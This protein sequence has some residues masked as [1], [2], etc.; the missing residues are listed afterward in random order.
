MK[1]EGLYRN[2]YNRSSRKTVI[3]LIWC[4]FISIFLFF[5]VCNL[6]NDQPLTTNDN[7]T[8]VIEETVEE[9]TTS[10][11]GSEA[12][13]SST[14]AIEENG[15]EEVAESVELTINVYYSDSMG[16]YLAAEARIISSGNKY[17][18]AFN[19]LM[20]PPIDSNLVSLV[21]DTT[22]INSIIVE[23]GTAN[24]DLS[25]DFIDDRFISDTVDIML[26]YCIVNTLTEFDEVNS[27]LFYIDGEKLDILGQLDILDPVFRR[28]DLIK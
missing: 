3:M 15:D 13:G 24:V 27:V 11:E 5:P 14:E 22:I 26:V 19:E 16:E 10:D 17:V 6:I 18:D 8:A 20:K 1:N 2:N 7:D 28:S 9:S 25:N 12:S 23:N 4:I 21:P